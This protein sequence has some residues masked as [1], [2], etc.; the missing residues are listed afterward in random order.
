MLRPPRIH[1]PQT[2]CRLAH[3]PFNQSSHDRSPPRIQYDFTRSGITTI[4]DL[5]TLLASD[6]CYYHSFEEYPCLVDD[7]CFCTKQNRPS[8]KYIIARCISIGLVLSVFL[9]WKLLIYTSFTAIVG[10]PRA[11]SLGI[12]K[13]VFLSI[14]L[15]PTSKY[16]L[17]TCAY[18]DLLLQWSARSIAWSCASPKPKP[19][20]SNVSLHLLS[21]R[22]EFQYSHMDTPPGP[23]QETIFRWPIK[24]FPLLP[25]S[26]KSSCSL[27]SSLYI[28][29]LTSLGASGVIQ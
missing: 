20:S 13:F 21:C 10:N 19:L 7:V 5:L 9:T 14:T 8:Y 17:Q 16:W 15:R 22:I 4:R 6:L 1:S 11:L 12:L 26:S 18:C 2:F 3:L 27:R 24:E 28:T 25:W 23:K 29:G